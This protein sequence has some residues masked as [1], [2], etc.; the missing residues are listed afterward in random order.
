MAGPWRVRFEKT[1]LGQG[2]AERE[3][4]Q[5][6]LGYVVWP[7]LYAHGEDEPEGA[8]AICPLCGG[9][10]TIWFSNKHLSS[11]PVWQ[12]N[13]D[14]DKPT[15]SPSVLSFNRDCGM[16]VWVRD[17]QII[18]AGTPAHGDTR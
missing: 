1:N 4:R 3:Q 5:Q 13:G 17:G 7:L 18:D 10:G 14:A 16:H 2:R 12:W 11:R 9:A 15:L 8:Y 6:D